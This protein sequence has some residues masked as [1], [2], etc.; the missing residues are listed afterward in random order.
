MFGYC[1]KRRNN[2]MAKFTFATLKEG[3][4]DK[5]FTYVASL[6]SIQFEP[7]D[8]DVVV[9]S[10]FDGLPLTHV[11]FVQDY[12]PAHEHWHDWHHPTSYGSEWVEGK[13]STK[14]GETIVVPSH[15]KS[16]TLPST[17]KDVGY[18]AFRYHSTTTVQFSKDN[19]RANDLT[20]YLK[21]C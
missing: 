19:P 3:Y 18:H 14:S 20:K 11:C 8:T 12:V 6:V 1:N 10:S 2:Y 21:S 17:V 5:P 4:E 15:V 16:L 13:Y 9:P 7:T